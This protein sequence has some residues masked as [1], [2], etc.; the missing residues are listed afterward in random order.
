[1]WLRKISIL[2]FGFGM[3]FLGGC[4][5]VQSIA[6]DSECSVYESDEKCDTDIEAVPMDSDVASDSGEPFDST[7][8]R[9]T[10]EGVDTA[11]D[12]NA[13]D[14]ETAADSDSETT[15]DSDS[16]TTADSDS[17]T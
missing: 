11:S 6:V 16:E 4:Y 15:A 5:G 13:D 8:S 1:M 12:T 7:Y 14:T 17:E 3:L 9:D 10:E 2:V